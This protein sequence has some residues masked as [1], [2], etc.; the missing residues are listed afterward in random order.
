MFAMSRGLPE[1]TWYDENQNLRLL[2]VPLA[3]EDL[4]QAS[5]NPVRQTAADHTQAAFTIMETLRKL[6]T[7][8]QTENQITALQQQ[9][10]ALYQSFNI[11]DKVELDQ[12]TL[13]KSYEAFNKRINLARS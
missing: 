6:A 8:A 4:L 10:E 1:A 7:K 3:F 12:E 2:T 5:L 9:A 13:D 11:T